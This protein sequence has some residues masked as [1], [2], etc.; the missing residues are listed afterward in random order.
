[1]ST[2]SSEVA[3][4]EVTI[5]TV[6]MFGGADASAEA[7]ANVVKAFDDANEYITVVDESTESSEE[8]KS[9]VV[10]SF[11]TGDNA[12]VVFFFTTSDAEPMLDYVVPLSEIKEVYPDYCNWISQSAIESV[13]I[14]GVQYAIP[15]KGYWE[16]LFVNEDLYKNNGIDL[17]SDWAKFTDSFAKLGEKDIIPM[18]FGA[19]IPHYWIEHFILAAG[20]KADHAANPGTD[21]SKV[22]QSWYTGLGF[23][24][25]L[26][27]LGGFAK[28]APSTKYDEA[29]EQ[30]INK[31]AALSV[32]GS[33]WCGSIV[34]ADTTTVMAMPAYA[35]A[36]KSTTDVIAGF[37]SGFYIARS[38]WDDE[39]KRDACV[40][41]VQAATSPEA[42][43][44][45]VAQGGAPTC[46]ITADPN[47]VAPRPAVDGAAMVGAADEVDIPLGDRMATAYAEFISGAAKI[48]NGDAKVEDVVAAFCEANK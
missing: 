22:P 12:D 7:Y 31:K 23:F 6:S 8:W 21:V 33:W 15:V 1:E 45:Y 10:S 18:A 43:A 2:V 30:F 42:V 26:Y 27:D 19:D 24:K 44:S 48:M 5:K 20:P 34:D 4:T 40:Q 38:A 47:V 13:A 16:G 35:E 32:D 46:A 41:F 9:A 17:P 14:D 29:C 11:E 39:A 36:G 25:D 28:A 3:P 37:S